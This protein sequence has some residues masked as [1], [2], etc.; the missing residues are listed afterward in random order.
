MVYSQ[1]P[2]AGRNVAFGTE[3]TYYATSGTRKETV[4]Q[5]RAYYKHAPS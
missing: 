5:C 2:A 1:S 4:A 3:I